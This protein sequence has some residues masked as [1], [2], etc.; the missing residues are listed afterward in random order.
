MFA[1]LAIPS[2]VD[3]LFTYSVPEEFRQNLKP[4]MRVTAPFGRRTVTGI[5]IRDRKSVV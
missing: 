4:G 2:A 3:K 1:E 5:V